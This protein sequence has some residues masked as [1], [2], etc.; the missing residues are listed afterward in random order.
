MSAK[1]IEA[2]G[3]LVTFGA[4]LRIDC[5]KCGASRTLTGA[6]I[7]KSLRCWRSE[8]LRASAEVREC[9]GKEAWLTVLPPL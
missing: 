3:D 5:A 2:T 7:A 6:E 8:G 9:G 1:H 4:S